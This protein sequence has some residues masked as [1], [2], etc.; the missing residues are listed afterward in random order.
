VIDRDISRLKA[1][2]KELDELQKQVD[3]ILPA[4][5]RKLKARG[6]QVD[7]LQMQIDALIPLVKSLCKLV[8]E[9]AEADDRQE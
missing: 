8:L 6:E 7:A 2:A 9:L 3:A 5:R 1:K 4:V